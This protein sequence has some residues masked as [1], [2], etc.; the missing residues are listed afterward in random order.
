MSLNKIK[1]NNKFQLNEMYIIGLRG[2][3]IEINSEEVTK[4]QKINLN[5]KWQS[6]SVVNQVK[7]LYELN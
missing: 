5:G 1:P 6:F 3:Q 2:Y 4:V 7:T